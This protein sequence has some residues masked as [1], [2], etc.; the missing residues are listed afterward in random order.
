MFTIDI[1]HP[2]DSALQNFFDSPRELLKSIFET[3]DDDSIAALGLIFV[4]RGWLASPIEID[5]IASEFLA[6]MGASLGG[7]TRAL[8]NLNESLVSMVVRDQAHG[9]VFTHPTMIDA[10]ADLLRN[11]ELLHLLISGF[12]LQTLIS[13]TSCGDLSIENA[14]I[15]R[16]T[17]GQ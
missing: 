16:R 7:V 6:R 10:Y 17:C 11:P 12:D 13:Q 9:W 4:N 2:M 8:S 1:G 5:C 15:V 3:L 14:I